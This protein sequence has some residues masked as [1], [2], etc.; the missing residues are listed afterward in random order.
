MAHNKRPHF[1]DWVITGK[2]NLRCLHCRGMDDGELSTERALS[3]LDEMAGLR[4]GWLIIE[5]G[6]PLLR[7]DIFTLLE[8]AR[9]LG[10]EVY[11]ITSGMLLSAEIIEKLSRLAVRVMVSIDGATR[12]T[13]E[14]IRQGANF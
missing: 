2:C 12:Q 4:P 11:L 8:K 1:I 14:A 9:K 5:G 3:L 10:L 13:Y 6:E 7:R